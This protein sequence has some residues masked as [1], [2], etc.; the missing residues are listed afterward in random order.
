MRKLKKL[1]FHDWFKQRNYKLLGSLKGAFLGDIEDIN[2]LKSF[3][4]FRP[5]LKF[6]QR[7]FCL[8]FKAQPLGDNDEVQDWEVGLIG[9]KPPNFDDETLGG[10][11]TYLTMITPIP[12]LKG[13]LKGLIIR[14][15][16]H[17]L[18]P[19]TPI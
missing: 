4:D 10:Y 17:P 19:G 12:N 3:E 5:W 9:A 11:I 14:D 6:L 18:H 8:G 13:K 1:P 2:L 15:P 16:Q 7:R